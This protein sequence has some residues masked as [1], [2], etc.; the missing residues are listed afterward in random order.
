MDVDAVAAATVADPVRNTIRNDRTTARSPA[1]ALSI[2]VALLPTGNSS[3]SIR[4]INGM[5]VDNF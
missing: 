4:F 5:Q 2:G 3:W 1:T